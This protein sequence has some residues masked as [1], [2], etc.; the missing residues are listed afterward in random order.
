VEWYGLTPSRVTDYQTITG[1]DL[2]ATNTFAAP[3]RVIPQ[4]LEPPKVGSRM[5]FQ[6][7]ARSYTVATL[8]L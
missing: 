3:K 6:L 7:P 4:T 8:A 5:I 2:K 1:S